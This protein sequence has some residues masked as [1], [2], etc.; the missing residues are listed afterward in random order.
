MFVAIIFEDIGGQDWV[1]RV[2]SVHGP[3][4]TEGESTYVG[5]R[6][7]DKQANLRYEVCPLTEQ[8]K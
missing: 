8:P 1:D 6:E 7:T 5:N 2:K 4:T 3:F